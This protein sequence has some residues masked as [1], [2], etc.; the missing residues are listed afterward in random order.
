MQLKTGRLSIDYFRQKFQ[1][2]IA[3][4]FREA[5]DDYRSR[6]L[7]EIDG[8]TIRLTRAGLLRA[9]ALLPAFFEPE[10]RGVR[11]T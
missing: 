1:V 6:Q 11:Y 10:Y 8:D 9:D 5:W 3:A 2:D 4:E 7:V